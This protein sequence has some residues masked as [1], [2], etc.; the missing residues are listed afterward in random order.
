MDDSQRI[1]KCGNLLLHTNGGFFKVSG[2]QTEHL[3]G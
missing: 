3:S 2:P 1:V